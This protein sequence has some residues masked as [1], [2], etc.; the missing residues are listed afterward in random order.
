MKFAIVTGSHRRDAQSLKVGAWIA[1]EIPV[2]IPDA[3]AEV[4]SLSGSPLPLW[5]ED[6]LE[7]PPPFLLQMRATLQAADALVVVAPEWNGTV[8]AGLKNFFHYTSPD[9]LGH[10]PGLL[11]GVSA[12]GGGTYPVAELRLGS[13][14]NNRLCYIPENI[15]V[16]NVNA[17]LNTPGAE[18]ASKEDGYLRRRT[19]Y[20][21]RLL[22]QYALALRAVRA[23]GVVDHTA[24]PNGL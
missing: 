8:A 17:N 5:E 13:A 11:V 18:G 20:A 10:K 19:H 12:G 23:S 16:R 9:E 7:N 6:V 1:A 2:L 14:K 24:W 21:L 15:V 4:L 3:T 22:H